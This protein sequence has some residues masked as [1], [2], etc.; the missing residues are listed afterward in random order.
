M[1]HNLGQQKKYSCKTLHLSN[2]VKDHV[3]NSTGAVI[4]ISTPHGIMFTALH[5]EAEMFRRRLHP[6]GITW[7]YIGIT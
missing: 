6:V 3:M 5:L 7:Y 4:V 2:S 1:S